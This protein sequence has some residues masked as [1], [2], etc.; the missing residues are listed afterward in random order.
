MDQGAR[1]LI[2]LFTDGQDNTSVLDE[3]QVRTVAERS[4]AL[5][6]VVGWNPPESTVAGSPEQAQIR[7]LGDL[8]EAT[9]GRF[10][11]A[12]SPRHLQQAFAAIANAMSERYVLRYEPR[13]VQREGWHRLEVRQ[14]GPKGKVQARRGYWV[15]KP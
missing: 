1:S 13:G 4:N 11:T 9:G 3:A 8:A 5:I 15:A 6:H 14:R 10:W 12:Q 7:A 2:V